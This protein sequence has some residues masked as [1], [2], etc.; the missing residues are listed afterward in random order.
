VIPIDVSPLLR[1]LLLERGSLTR[2]LVAL[3]GGQF[4]VRL[5]HMRYCTPLPHE[6]GVLQ[7][8]AREV[9]LV[10]EVT[11]MCRETPIVYARS[12]IPMRAMHGRFR[13][14]RHLGTQPLGEFLFTAPGVHRGDMK[15]MR[16]A[17]NH[18]LHAGATRRAGGAREFWGR[19]SL[20]YIGREPLLVTEIFLSDRA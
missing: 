5:D 3:A 4:R 6:A 17:A 10:R 1:S 2:R 8:R 11:L 19:Q 7:L 12:A 20:F 16:V 9:A 14:L 13:R 15:I 18:A